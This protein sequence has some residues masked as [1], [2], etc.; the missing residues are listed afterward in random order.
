MSTPRLN[1][2]ELEIGQAQPEVTFNEAMKKLD[3]FAMPVALA[4]QNSPPTSPA[5]G[6]IYIV[7][8][9]PTGVWQ[10]HSG[11]I[12]QYYNGAWVYYTPSAG[13]CFSVVANGLYVYINTIWTRKITY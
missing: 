13:W 5:E 9:S 3:V 4:I 8:T 7:G 2:D 6:N 12:A 10:T 11:Q 1:L